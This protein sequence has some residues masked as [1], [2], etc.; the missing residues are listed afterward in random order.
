MSTISRDRTSADQLTEEFLELVCADEE[1]LR[2]EFDEIIAQEWTSPP[3]PGEPRAATP[4]DGPRRPLT[5]PVDAAWSRPR[6]CHP[7]IPRWRRQRSPP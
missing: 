4:G 1:L 3:P 2:A 7:L 5:G 6:A